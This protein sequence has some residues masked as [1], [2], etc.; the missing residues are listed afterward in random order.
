MDQTA[1]A[2]HAKDVTVPPVITL[3]RDSTH[4]AMLERIIRERVRAVHG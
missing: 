1:R 3:E 2:V 4:T